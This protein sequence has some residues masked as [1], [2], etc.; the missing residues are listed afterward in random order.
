MRECASMPKGRASACVCVLDGKGYVFAGRETSS[1]SSY[2]NDLW[3]YDPQTDSWIDLGTAP[4]KKRVNATIAAANGKLYAGLGYAGLGAY[5]DSTYLQDWWEY[6]PATG[7]WRALAQF[8]TRNTVAAS[9]FALDGYIY[10]IYGFG[11]GWTRDVWRYSIAED[12]WEMVPDNPKRAEAVGG[13]RGTMLDG[14]FYFGTGYRTYNETQWFASDIASDQWTRCASIP[15]KGRE[16]G[17]CA[18]SMDFVYL[19]GG[20]HFAGDMTGGEIFETYMRY[21]PAKDRWEWCGTMPFGRAE[22]LIAFSINGK[23]YFGL[24]E[25]EKAETNNKLYCIEE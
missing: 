3:Q 6:T 24:G 2:K 19:F 5:R 1:T 18:A 7:V 13:G 12:K 15:G 10:A 16:V 21:S 22:N 20:R 17:A 4:M 9:S 11:W 23:V 8:P 25:N 14:V